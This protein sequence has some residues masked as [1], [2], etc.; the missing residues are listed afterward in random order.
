MD[1]F[2]TIKKRECAILISGC[3]RNAFSTI[4]SFVENIVIS[5]NAD[6]FVLLRKNSEYDCEHE[7]KMNT[8]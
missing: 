2:D 7:K 3:A 8:I 6:V 4:D 1:L 5:N